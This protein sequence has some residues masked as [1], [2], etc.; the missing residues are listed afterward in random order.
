MSLGRVDLNLLVALEAL[1][2]EANVTRAAERV[3]LSQ[4]AMSD[5]LQRLRR[6][7]GDELLVRVGRQYQLTAFAIE[8]QEPLHELVQMA[9]DIIQRRELFEPANDSRS[10]N[11]V[12]SEYSAYILI[13]PVLQRLAHAAPGLSLRLQRSTPGEHEKM[14]SDLIVGLWPGTGAAEFGLQSE[15]LFHD[16]WVCIVWSGNEHI[17][18]TLSLQQYMRQPHALYQASARGGLGMADRTIRDMNL[19]RRVQVSVDS[20]VLLPLLLQGTPQVALIQERL[21]RKLAAVADVRVVEPLFDTPPLAEAMYWHSRNTS[22][23][24]HRWLRTM[25]REVAAELNP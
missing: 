15:I 9:G 14:A 17:G 6:L 25:L 21:G 4:P 24:A 20:F 7:F 18:D 1:L 12:A 2:D 11:V 8:L 22:D 13:Q 10:F 5:A 3:H 23:P 16:R 19:P